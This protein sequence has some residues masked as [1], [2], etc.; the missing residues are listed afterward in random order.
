M[1]QTLTDKYIT[2]TMLFYLEHKI[3]NRKKW[4]DKAVPSPPKFHNVSGKGLSAKGI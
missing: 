2:N 3:A 1:T 4:S